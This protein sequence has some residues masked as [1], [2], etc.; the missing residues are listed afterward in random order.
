MSAKINEMIESTKQKWMFLYN[1]NCILNILIIGVYV[2]YLTAF[3][4]SVYSPLQQ[5]LVIYLVTAITSLK[6]I[7][8]DV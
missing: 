6:L 1:R 4:A 3:F 8:R 7:I 2:N 5:L